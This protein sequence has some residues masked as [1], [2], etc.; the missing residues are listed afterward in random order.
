MFIHDCIRL[1]LVTANIMSM[2][3]PVQYHNWLVWNHLVLF[4]LHRTGPAWCSLQNSVNYMQESLSHTNTHNPMQ[5]KP[6]MKINGWLVYTYA[7][8]QTATDITRPHGSL[9][10]YQLWWTQRCMKTA[11]SRH[12]H[13]GTHTLPSRCPIWAGT[14]TALSLLG[15]QNSSYGICEW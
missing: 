3:S 2:E 9:S 13:T 8:T 5:S 1:G 6:W 4:L 7:H 10:K 15:K 11:C 12:T 14:K